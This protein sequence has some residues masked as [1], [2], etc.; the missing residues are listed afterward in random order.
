VKRCCAHLANIRFERAC[1]TL[2]SLPSAD[3]GAEA[4]H[5]AE[6]ARHG[7]MVAEPHLDAAL[8]ERSS[9]I[10]LDVRKADY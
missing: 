7:P 8:D 1:V 6:D 3:H 4:A 9:D 2:A 5:V 10:G